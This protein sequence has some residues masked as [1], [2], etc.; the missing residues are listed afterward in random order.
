M[1]KNKRIWIV[2][3]SILIMGILITFATS[4]FVKSKESEQSYE[5]Y[6]VEAKAEKPSTEVGTEA[7]SAK[8]KRDSPPARDIHKKEM[9]E[10]TA[11]DK[12]QAGGGGGSI[13]TDNSSIKQKSLDVEKTELASVEEPVISPVN[14]LSEAELKKG[15]KYYEKRL[16]DLDVQIETMHKE[17]QSTNTYSMK[18]L[19]DKEFNLWDKEQQAIYQVILQQ[20]S[21]KDQVTLKDSQTAFIKDRDAK[22]EEAVKRYSGGSL[23]ELEYTESLIESSRNR[24]YALVEEYKDVFPSKE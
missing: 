1:N 20:L 12:P 22:A 5:N 7:V 21:D 24:A 3:G 19:A 8:L 17:A 11:N 10:T 15:V 18:V 2:I 16:K 14:G 9:N 23:E 6:G 13:D 4:S